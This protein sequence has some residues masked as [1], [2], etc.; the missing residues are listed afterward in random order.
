MRPKGTPEEFA[1]G[2]QQFWDLAGPLLARDD[3]EEGTLM[4]SR[5]LRVQGDFVAMVAPS[6]QMV[7]KLPAARVQE[8]VDQ[9]V[10]EPFAPAKRVFK[11]WLA[12]VGTDEAR[13]RDLL[14]EA[15]AFVRG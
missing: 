11:E 1:A 3:T 15:H 9:G 6:G 5:C 4:N 2:E 14:H 13:W 7:V 12:V 8:L 10:G